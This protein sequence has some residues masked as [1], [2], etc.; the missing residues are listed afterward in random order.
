M[1]N[2]CS[3]VL[4]TIAAIFLI[5]YHIGCE[6]SDDCKLAETRCSGDIAQICNEDGFWKNVFHCKELDESWICCWAEDGQ[7]HT[8][9]PPEECDES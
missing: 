3:L 9:L 1:L 4:F 8:C 5:L 6:E 7:F 2:K